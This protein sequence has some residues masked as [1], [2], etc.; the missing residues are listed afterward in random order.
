MSEVRLR[1]KDQTEPCVDTCDPTDPESE[2][3]EPDE[4]YDG[5]ASACRDAR[6]GGDE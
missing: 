6:G 4:G 3:Y 5:G 1:L 2:A